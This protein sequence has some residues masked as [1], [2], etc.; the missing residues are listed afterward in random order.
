[1]IDSNKRLV[2][3]PG[4]RLCRRYSD[5][6]SPNQAR[7]LSD[8]DGIHIRPAASSLLQCFNGNGKHIL[9]MMA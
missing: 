8:R 4:C 6:K 2:D 5:K 1:M 7:P 9:Y 3:G